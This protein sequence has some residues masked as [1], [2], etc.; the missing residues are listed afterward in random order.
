MK[1]LFSISHYEKTIKPEINVICITYT[2]VLKKTF[3]FLLL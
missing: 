1:K 3:N 2:F